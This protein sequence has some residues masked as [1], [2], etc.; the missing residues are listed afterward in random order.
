MPL[1]IICGEAFFM[2][3]QHLSGTWTL[4][5]LSSTDK[6]TVNVS[7]I[8]MTIP[9]DNYTA[10]IQSGILTDPYY[11][12]NEQNA[13]W[14]G[15][16]DW[17]I[18]R[19]FAYKRQVDSKTYLC[20]N[21]V[22]TYFSVF[23][24]GTKAGS[25]EN[26]FRQWRFDITDLLQ[27]GENDISIQFDAPE[28]R[29]L[30]EA[31]NLPHPIPFSKYDVF[32]PHR[33]LTRKIQCQAGWDWGPCLMTSGIYGDI[34]LDTVTNGYLESVTFNA[35]PETAGDLS[36]TWQATAGIRYWAERNG[37]Q[38]FRIELTGNGISLVQTILRQ[39]QAGENSTTV[40]FEVQHPK[41]W[42]N[43]DELKASGLAKNTL[44][45]LHVVALRENDSG[46]KEEDSE[47]TKNVAFRTLILV[48]Q[49]DMAGCALYFE[50]NGRKVFA[51]GANCIPVDAL[52][53]RWTKERY[54]YLIQSATEANMNA[55]RVWGG[56]QYESD[57]FY[58]ICDSLGIIVW[59]DCAFAC[60]LYPATE[61]FLANVEKE[62][63]D[64]V[65]R[66]QSHPSLA[67][68]CGNNENL[69]ALTW[70]EESRKNRDVYLTDYDRL[71]HGVI[72][73]TIK[74]CDPE[75]SWWPSSPSAG[76]DVFADN[77]HS[78]NAGDMHFWSVWHGKEDMEKFMSITPRFVSEFGYESFPSL[79]GVLEFTNK[80]HLNVTDPILEYHQRSPSG[81]SIILENFSRY[82][83]FP[84]GTESQLYLSQVQQA[85]AIKTAVQYWRSLRPHCMGAMY[86]QLNDV[87]PTASW[88]SIEYSGK[89][90][91]L[92]YAA[93]EFFSPISLSFYKKDEHIYAYIINETETTEDITLTIQCY[94]FYGTPL[95]ESIVLRQTIETDSSVRLWSISE[96]TFL[97]KLG[98][99]IK[100]D[101]CFLFATIEKKG[102]RIASNTLFLERWK[103]CELQE[104]GIT[105]KVCKEAT[106][107]A[108]YLTTQKP[109]FFVALDVP[110][111]K[112]HFSS[113]MLTLLPEQTEKIGFVHSDYGR[114]DEKKEEKSL[115]GEELTT[116]FEKNLRILSLKSTY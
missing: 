86:W 95:M 25:G 91:L 78:D 7:G 114:V 93:K 83:R 62:I 27:D 63:E 49:K 98:N 102:C 73:K 66:L 115:R 109:A 8:P 100:A 3:K 92:H 75:R 15:R 46:T 99:G 81:N 96:Q 77:W 31:Q 74:R 57:T 24:N 79:E 29:A 2:N 88:S 35:S 42:K 105:A 6:T 84:S 60:S 9:G 17:R 43:A 48:A 113:N 54:E 38:I 22:D 1:R 10:L 116:T 19:K 28:R 5:S 104:P 80:E 71:N 47:I 26:Y 45:K 65:Y 64:N 32:S 103:R 68:W 111:I 11:G 23:I 67:V 110:G 30:E 33:N 44:Y 58:E 39:V 50:L 85:L 37:K 40:S 106:G 36:G 18:Q 90:K 51:K 52:P 101:E 56:N 97:T 89:W 13:L 107:I 72:E 20:A 70:Y 55:L 21:M 34:Y 16:T 12:C 82:F 87:W 41:L 69:G 94:D 76:P 108:V 14:A 4:T 53:S 59:Q 61:D 112:G